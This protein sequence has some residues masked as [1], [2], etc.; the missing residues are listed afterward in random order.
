VL[1]LQERLS[2]L[3]YWLGAPDANYGDLTRQAVV[4]FQKVQGLERDGIAGPAVF[5]ALDAPSAPGA[6]STTGH[7]MEV[8]LSTQ[9]VK[10]VDDGRVSLVLNTATGAAATSTPPGTYSITRE[11][12]GMRNA[13]LGQLWRPKYFVGGVAFH[14]YPSV[15]SYPASHGCVRLSYPAM[16]MVWSTG[17]APVGTSVLV[18]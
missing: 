16:D 7:V 10:V 15:P 18:Y 13:P 8:D 17:L 12:D 2:S 4:A 5:A 11:I 14:G 1:A 9:V 6:S 3:G